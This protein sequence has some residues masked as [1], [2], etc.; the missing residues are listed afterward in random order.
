MHH[1][2]GK[3]IAVFIEDMFND[4]E[5][6]YPYYRMR[7]TGADVLTLGPKAGG[8]YSSKHGLTA[9]ADKAFGDIAALDLDA[10]IIPGG[11][12]PDRMR[13]NADCLQ[14]VRDMAQANKVTAFIC[15]A[16]WVPVSA[17]V[18]KG[19]KCTS[20]SSIKDD[21]V[22]AGAEWTDEE[23]VVDLPLISS[24]TPDDLPAFC[25]EIVKALEAS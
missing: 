17:D 18:L 21:M 13:R 4:Y 22:N 12:A 3:T 25:R 2:S 15:H 23:V 24:R 11:Y 7:E 6:I 5:Y 14:L 8:V 16:G 10:V 1:L 20:Y 19:K 9:T